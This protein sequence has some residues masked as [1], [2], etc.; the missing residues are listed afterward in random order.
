[1][2]TDLAA[3]LLSNSRA[4]QGTDTFGIDAE[5]LQ[6][7]HLA[8]QLLI[9]EAQARGLKVEVIDPETDLFRVYDQ[10]HSVMLSAHANLNP[11]AAVQL[12]NNK[13]ATKR[14]LQQAGLRVPEGKEYRSVAEA[15]T[16]FREFSP[17]AVRFGVVI[18]PK[19]GRNGAG[20]T[21]L[22]GAS[23]QAEWRKAFSQALEN[24][25]GRDTAV[26]AEEFVPGKDTRFLV[27]G[28]RVVAI[29]Q[30]IPANVVGDGQLT[31]RELV[32]IKNMQRQRLGYMH[33]PLVLNDVASRELAKH[34]LQFESVSPV[35]QTAYLGRACNLSAGADVMDITD[36]VHAG[37]CELAVRA[38]RAVSAPLVGLDF[39]VLDPTLPPT[40]TNYAILEGNALPGY[41]FHHGPTLG[42]GRNAVGAILDLYGF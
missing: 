40:P 5:W 41:S 13:S 20:I 16:A 24:D 30:R 34:G 39:Q 14:V 31:V 35:G 26:L 2:G 38:S 10:K 25:D 7:Q 6:K 18:K 23:T 28:H 33:H 4:S 22:D 21:F 37:Y 29:A 3:A 9:S 15:T 32:A 12:L 17:H 19:D 8:M 42:T 36:S 1:M 27:V 11:Y